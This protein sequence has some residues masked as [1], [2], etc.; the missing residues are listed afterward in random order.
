M[1]TADMAP[2][3]SFEES[4]VAWVLDESSLDFLV[5]SLADADEVVIDLETTGLHEQAWEGGR[6][7][8]GVGARVVLAQFTL[9]RSDSDQ[10]TNWVVPLSHPD[11]PFLGNWR[12]VLRRLARTIV[13]YR[14]PVIGQNVKFDTRWVYA[15]TG[16]DLA[17][18]IAWDTRVSSHLLDENTS[19][20]LKDRAPATFAHLG[21]VRWDDFSLSSPGA[22]ERVPLFDLG[23]YGARDTY[24]TWALSRVHRDRMYPDHP[25]VT[26]DEVE[27]A[28]LGKLAAWV[29]MPMVATL[30]D[31]E[32]RGFLLDVEWVRDALDDNRTRKRALERSLAS[33]YEV[34]GTP[35]FSPTA[36]WFR[37]WATA[38][39]NAGDLEVAELTPT[40]K[41]KWSKNVLVRQARAGKEV[42]L[43]LLAV[44]S[45]AKKIEYLNAWLSLVS[46]DSRIHAFYNVG[47]VITGRLSSSE[48]NMQQ[49]TSSL[50]QAFIPTPGYVLADIDY[51]QIELRVAAH[52][53]GCVPMIEAFRRGDDL[54]TLLAADVT[55]KHPDDVTKAERQLGKAGNFGLLYGMGAYGF[56]AYAE[57]AY[58]VSFSVKDAQH[59]YRTFFDTWDGMAQWHQRA[60]ARV[61][62]TGQVVS[63]IG[64][65]RRLPGALSGDDDRV[66]AAVRAAI[67]APVQGFASDLMQTAA[68]SIEGMLPN[69]SGVPGARIVATVHDSIVVEV[70][71][72]DWERATR[73]CIDRMVTIGDALT[74]MG[75]DLTVPLVAEAKVGTRWGLSDVGMLA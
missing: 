73:E 49:V 38:A 26:A 52:V 25:P 24:W 2:T 3:F 37:A 4:D 67:N 23:E 16:I 40:G 58:G 59:I 68:A 28:R 34:E 11:S 70:P 69:T 17:P 20:S 33:R 39:V 12:A 10:P 72:D 29:G 1:I 31:V 60:A 13:E 62:Q 21:L 43:D 41:P 15:T 50:R 42:A 32:Q 44:R 30:A 57:E 55:G 66:G 5:A 22:A 51:S 6:M 27:D 46:Q 36:H 8:S 53:S 47:T 35:T 65:V 19:T 64:R 56:R 61:I 54:H 48:P 45:H 71:E 14:K 18:Q 75:C 63:P 7:N 74:P 9:P